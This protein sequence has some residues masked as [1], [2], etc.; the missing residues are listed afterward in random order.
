[1]LPAYGIFFAFLFQEVF[2]I[3]T[4]LSDALKELFE[5]LELLKQN[6]RG[7]VSLIRH[8]SSG[9]KYILRSFRGNADVYRQ[10]VSCSSPYLPTVYEVA[11]RE[12]DHLILEEYVSGDNMGTMLK[13]ALF[14]PKET[15]RIVRDLCYALWVLHSMGAVHRDVKPENVLL[16]EGRAVL[17]DFDAARFFK[18][19]AD[20][21][22]Q[23]L[24]TT[25]F[26]APEQYGLSQSDA[27][28]DIY[29]LGV[30]INILL[31]GCHPSQKLAS[32]KWGRIVTR[33][34]LVSPSKRYKN[35]LSL[36]AEL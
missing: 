1:M 35:V 27:G 3:Y 5:P 24:G 12:Y 25:G 15:R 10:L 9:T 19:E 2:S 36:L 26:A 23:I 29:A 8:K 6:E 28:A 18:E 30:L 22:T 14:T 13:E 7:S 20:S 34:T 33:C 11:S 16:R 17:I 21:D 31:T 32:G 4:W